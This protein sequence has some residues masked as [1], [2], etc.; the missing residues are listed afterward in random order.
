MRITEIR[1]CAIPVSR[2]ADPAIPSGGLT[3]SLVAVS[4]DVVRDGKPVVGYGFASVGRFAQGGLM[5][6]RFIPR[7]MN[8]PPSPTKPE[9]TSMPSRPGR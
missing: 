1:E 2:Y 5:R 6:E 7:L 4:T 3:T 9:P 8:A